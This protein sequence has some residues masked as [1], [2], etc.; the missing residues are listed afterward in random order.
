[1]TTAIRNASTRDHP[2]DKPDSESPARILLDPLVDL[3]KFVSVQPQALASGTPINGDVVNVFLPENGA[4]Y[5]ASKIAG[6]GTHD[7]V[8]SSSGSGRR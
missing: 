3:V 7:V 4:V 1:M 6:F 5:R 8:V 2:D